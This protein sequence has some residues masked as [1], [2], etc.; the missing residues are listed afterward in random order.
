MNESH[1]D[2][3]ES[4]CN[5]SVGSDPSLGTGNYL[6]HFEVISYLQ[7]LWSWERKDRLWIC[8]YF[9]RRI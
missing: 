2:Q 6:Q 4:S 1:V 9:K 3:W 5:G 7:R 8:M